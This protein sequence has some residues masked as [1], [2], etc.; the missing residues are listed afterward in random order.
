MGNSCTNGSRTAA[1]VLGNISIGVIGV[2]VE[3]GIVDIPRC[4]FSLMSLSMAFASVML[5]G[6]LPDP[7]GIFALTN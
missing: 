3:V 1:K 2:S 7:V 4:K 5:S 6:R